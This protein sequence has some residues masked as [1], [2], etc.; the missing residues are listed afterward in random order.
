MTEEE[1]RVDEDWKKQVQQEK[2]KVEE[3]ERAKNKFLRQVLY[4]LF[5]DLPHKHTY[6]WVS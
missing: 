5:Q 2:E 1:K 6:I 4:S 3:E